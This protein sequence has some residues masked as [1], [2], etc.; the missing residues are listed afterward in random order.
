MTPESTLAPSIL[1]RHPVVI[2]GPQLLHELVSKTSSDTDIA[3]DFLEN[4]S[5]RRR[6]SYESLHVLSDGLA[7]TIT[8]VLEKLED[9][10]TIVPV[11]LP[12]SPELYVTLLAISKAGGSFCSLSPDTPT[13]RLNFILRDVS[14]KLII[15]DSAHASMIRAE[16]KARVLLVDQELPGCGNDPLSRRRAV[17]TNHLAYV[18]YTSGSTGLPK[19][20]C[21]SHR[22][23]TQSLLAHDRHI[24][25]FSRFL[26]FAAPTFDVSIFEI[27]FPWFRGCTLVG[28]T[29]AQM[30]NDLPATMASLEADAAEL[31]PT[32]CS[33]LMGR[34]SVPGLK[35][36]LTIG[37]MLTQSVV[38]EFGGDH[39]TD[40]ML[41]NMYGPTEASIHC[42]VQPSFT[43]SSPLSNIGFPLDTV[44]AMVVAPASDTLSSSQIQV[45]PVG[46]VGELVLGGPQI[47]EGYLNRPN[48]NKSFIRDTEYG[49]LY[50]TGDKARIGQ[51]GLLE[52][53]GRIAS[54]QVKLKGQR[55]ELGEIEQT[56]S[57]VDGCGAVV[58]M[59]I[60]DN[61]VAFCATGSRTLEKDAV[62][63]TCERWLPTFMIPTS[64]HFIRHM[65]LLESGK[66]NR[67]SLEAQYL[68][69]NVQEDISPLIPDDRTGQ[70]ILQTVKRHL[71]WVISLDSS[72]VSVGLD[73]LS[74]IQIASSLREQGYNLGAL[75]VLSAK[76]PKDLIRICQHTTAG[77][78]TISQQ[79]FGI[80]RE[81]ASDIPELTGLKDE[82][83]SI[84]PC[85]PLQEGML[86]ET[87]VR[88]NA[89]CNW[90]E[91]ELQSTRDF[92]EIRTLL[93]EI[94]Q[95]NEIL[96]SGFCMSTRTSGSFLQVV[97]KRLAQQ[98]IMEVTRFSKA[99]SLESVV[100]LLRPLVIQVNI[101]FERPRLLFQMH[102]ALYD[103]WSLDLLLNDLGTLRR[104]ATLD[105]RPQF[106]EVVKYHSLL[107]NTDELARDTEYWTKTLR[108]FHPISLPNFHGRILP[109]GT[110]QSV[111]LKSKINVAILHERA[112]ECGCNP[113]VFFQ[114]AVAYVM[115]L[116]LD[117]T[118]VVIGT[119][120][121]GR[122]IPITGIE[123]IQ[124]PCIASLPLRTDFSKCL[125]VSQLLK[126]VQ[127]TNRA[128]LQH[129]TLPLRDITKLCSSGGNLFEVLFVWQQNLISRDVED[130]GIK[131][132]D[133]ADVSGF[134]ITL[135]FEPHHDYIN[136]Q[137]TYDSTTIPEEQILFLSHQI[138][139]VVDYFL[140]NVD[141]TVDSVVNGFSTH[142]LSIAN[143]SPKWPPIRHGP[144][145]GVEQMAVSTPSKEAL[146]IG[147]I[148]DGIMVEKDK[149]T[150]GDL[151]ARANRVAHALISHG[152]GYDK[153]ICVLMEKSVNLYISILA[154][155]KVGSGYL[156]IAPDSP[157]ER[158]RKILADAGVEI[159]LSDSSAT[160]HL[161]ELGSYTVLDLDHIDLS[162][163]SDQNPAIAYDGAHL[164][165]AIFT[166]GSTGAPKGVLVTQDNLMSNLEELST[167]YPTSSDGRLLQSCSQA[168]DV[169]VFE[170]FFTW[171]NG[172]CL[173]TAAKDDLFYDLE[174]SI[175]QFGVTHLSLT[176][177]V[178]SLVDSS[179]VPKV[180]FLVTAGEAVT[181]HVKRQW[182][183]RGLYQGY[184]P[185]ETTNI[186][187]VRPRM[188][189]QDLINNIGS[190]LSN[191]SA[192]VL[193][194]NSV[195][196]RPR[197]A[198][199]ELCFGGAQVF[200]GYLNMPDL[201]A[202]KIV[203]HPRFGRIYRSGDMGM[204]LPDDSILF[205]RRVD[206]QVKIRGQRV[207]LA[208]ITST[209]LDNSTV[210]DCATLLL[211][212]DDSTQRLVAFWVPTEV[213]GQELKGAHALAVNTQVI[214]QKYQYSIRTIFDEL[215]LRLPS[216]MIPTHLVPI[217]RVPMTPQAK[218]DKRLLRTSFEGLTPEHLE[219][220]ASVQSS[221]E[222]LETLSDRERAFAEVLAQIFG[223]PPHRIRRSSSF[224]NMGLD[225]VSAIAF[226]SGLRRSGL[227]NISVSNILKNPTIARLS[228][229]D[230]AYPSASSGHGFVPLSS[231]FRQDQISHIRSEFQDRGLRVQQILPCTPIQEA[232]LSSTLRDGQMAYCNTMVFNV[233]GKMSRL[234]E[235]WSSIVARHAMLRTAFTQT[236]HEQYTFAQVVIENASIEWDQLRPTED[237]QLYSQRTLNGL[238]ESQKPPIGLATR[239]SG[240]LE[241][242]IFCCHHALYD[243][244]AISILEKEVQ[245]IYTEHTLPP[246]VP[247]EGYLQHMVSQDFEASD[248]FWTSALAGMEPKPFPNLTEKAQIATS[249]SES[250]GTVLQSP[251]GDVL[252][253]C[254]S[255]SVSLL[256]V[257][258][259]TWVKLLYLYTGED[260][261]CF[262]NV[263]SGRT[264]P[265]KD[266]DRLVAP[267]FNTLP[268]RVN[269]DF[270]RS[271]A[272]LIKQLHS[273]NI[274]SSPFQLTPLRRIQATAR[275]DLGH[276]FDTAVILQQPHE[277]LDESIWSLAHD[278]GSMDIPV[279]CEV[280][281]D[282]EDNLLRLVLHH[283]TS[284]FSTKEA[285]IIAETFDYVLQALL[286]FPASPAK[287]PVGFPPKILAESNKDFISH[288]LGESELLHS[289]ME[290]NAML[291]PDSIALEFHDGN[292]KTTWSFGILNERANEIAY[293]LIK[294][295]VGPED[296][297]PV[298]ISKSPQF[299]ASMLGILKAGAAFAPFAPFLPTTR[300]RFMLSD[301]RPKVLICTK[302]SYPDWCDNVDILNVD[303][304]EE[305]S[306]TNP[307]IRQ[308]SGTNLAYCLYTSGST[309]TPK[310]VLME[311]R[312]PIQ[313]IESSR[314]LIPWERRTSRLLQYAAITFDMCYYDC[315]LAWTFGFTLCAAEQ[316]SML[317]HLASTINSLDV[318]ILDLTPSVASIISR[319]EV[320]S[321]KW[322]FCIGETMLPEIV[323]EWE[324]TCVNSFGP[325]ETAF[326]NTIFAVGKNIKTTIIGKP[327][328]TTSFSVF[329]PKSTQSLPI[330]AVGELGIGG[331]Q[332]ARGYHG[333]AELTAQKF[334]YANGQRFY[335]SGDMV[336]MLANGNFEF[337]GRAD[338]QVKIR[339]LRVELGEISHALRNS[340]ENITTVTTQVLTLDSGTK[341]Q[342]VAFIVPRHPV[343][344]QEKLE[345]TRHAERA[346]KSSLP[347]YMVPQFFIFI[348]AIPLSFA[349]KVD[350]SALKVFFNNS[351]EARFVSDPSDEA[352]PEK[353]QWSATESQ[354]REVFAK[355]SKTTLERIYP[356][357]S[358][359]QLGLDSISAVQ[360]AAALQKQGL[361]VTAT[362]VMKYMNCTDLAAHID[363]SDER[364][365]PVEIAFDF[366]DFHK[367]HVAEITDELGVNKEDIEAIRPCTQLQKS[368]ISQFIAKDGAVYLNYV[369]F[370]LGADV[371]LSRLKAAWSSTMQKHVML[372]T[373][374]AHVQDNRHAFVMI[375]LTTAA[376][377]LP[378]NDTTETSNPEYDGW[379]DRMKN[380]VLNQLHRPPW[381][382]RIV[383]VGDTTC[384]DLAIHHALFDAQSLRRILQDVSHTYMGVVPDTPPPLDPALNKVLQLSERK[385]TQGS[386]FWQRLGNAATPT[387][388]PNVAPLRY[389]LTEPVTAT[390][391]CSHSLLDLEAGCRRLNITLQAAGIAAWASILSQYTGEPTITTGVVLS[392]RNFEGGELVVFPC[393]TT[394]PFVCNVSDNKEAMLKDIMD[395]SAEMQQHQFTPLNTIQG[396]MG[397]PN[398][399]LFDSIFAYQKFSHD[400]RQAE[401]WT[402]VDEKATVEFPISIELE[403]KNDRLE[404]RLSFL[405]HAVPTEQATLILDQLDHM[406]S[407]YV[408]LDFQA[409][410]MFYDPAIYSITPAKQ[411]SLPSKANLLHELVELTAL[412][413]P[414]RIALEFASTVRKEEY[415]SCTWTYAQLDAEGN[416]I[417]H[418]IL[419]HGVRPESLVGICFDKCPEASFAILGILKA[420]SAFVA[421]DPGSPAARQAFI[422][423]DSRVQIVLSMKNQSQRLRGKL[424]VRILDLDQLDLRSFPRTK[425]SLVRAIGPQDRSYC[426]YT[427][428]TT[429]TPKGCELTHE[430][431]VQ[432][433]LSFERLF[434]GHWN[435]ESRWLQFA[436][437]HFDVSVLEQYWS[438]MVGICVVSA[439]RDLLF[440]DLAGS[441]ES[442]RITHI[443]LTPS[444]ARI[445]HPD[446]VPSLCKGVFITGGESLTQEIL[447]VWG[448]KG[449]IYNG[450]GPTET[451]IGI[452]MYPGVPHN[453]KPSNIGRQFDNV[454]SFVLNPASEVPVLRGAIGEL[455]VSGKLVGKGYLNRPELTKERFPTLAHFNERV[456][457][458]GDLV[459]ILHDNDFDFI[460][461]VD[462][463]VKLRGQRLEIGEINSVIKRSSGGIL[464]VATLVLK[465]PKQQKD[466]LVSFVVSS[467]TSAEPKIVLESTTDLQKA[468]QACDE[469]LPGYMIPTHLLSITTLPLS[470]NNKI[471]TRKLR[472]MYEDLSGND[473]QLLSGDP[474]KEVIWSKDERK[475]RDVLKQVLEIDHDTIA[476]ESSFFELG[477]D[478]ISVIGLS[479][480]F[481]QAGFPNAT[482]SVLMKHTTIGKIAKVLLMDKT[483]DRG[484]IIAAQQ[485]ITAIQHRHRRGVADT[486]LVD[487][488][489]IEALA[490]CTPLQQGMIARALDSDRGLYFNAFQFKLDHSIN[491]DRLH[492][493]W[494]EVFR[495]TPILRT[496]FANTDDGYVQ[497]V[498][499]SM[500][501]P[502]RVYPLSEEE[503]LKEASE[504]LQREWW[505]LNRKELRRPFE[506]IFAT[507][508]EKTVLIVHIFHALYDGNSIEMM[509]RA[510]WNHYNGS[511]ESVERPSFLSALPHGP[512][513]IVD[514]SEEFWKTHL[515]NLSFTP[516]P[517][518]VDK[519][520]EG[521]IMVTRHARGVTDF[522][523]TRR[524]LNVTAQAIV[525]ACWISVM[526][527]HIHGPVTL[528]MVVSGR[529]IDFEGADRVIGP[530]FNTIPYQYRPRRSATWSSLIKETHD[531]NVAAHPFQHTP[532]RDIMKWCK[533]S[534][535]QP[536]FDTLFVYR[537]ANND[538]A[539]ANNGLAVLEDGEVEADFPL[540]IEIE[541]R[542][543]SHL[544]FTLVSQGHVL[545]R[546]TSEQLLNSLEESLKA[547]LA[548]PE[549]AVE[550]YYREEKFRNQESKEIAPRPIHSD[551]SKFGWTPTASIIRAEISSLAGIQIEGI[552]PSTSIFEL[553]LDSIDAIKLSSKLKKHDID[554]PV[555]GIMRSLTIAKMEINTINRQEWSDQP[556]NMIFET[557][558]RRLEN[559][560]RRR[561][562]EKTEIEQ[563]LPLTPLQEAMVA[564]MSASGYTRYYNHDVLR[565]APNT[566]I[567]KLRKAW[568]EVVEHSPILRTSFIEIDDPNIDYS[569]AQ[570]INRT[571]HY[572][573]KHKEITGQPD[574]A[575]IFESIRQDVAK[576][577]Y[578]GPPF[579]I[580]FLDSSVQ[581][582]L[583]LSIAHALYDGWSLSLL[584]ADVQDAYLGR[585]EAR[586]SYE[587]TLGEILT[588]S[589]TDAV[590]FWRDY[591]SDAKPTVFPR[592]QNPDTKKPVKVYRK[593]QTSA[594]D[595][596]SITSFAKANGTSLQTLG[597]T[598]YALVLASYLKSF[599]VTFGS[600]LSGRDDAV[601]SE[602]L[603]PTMTTVAV[604]TI[605]HGSCRDML[606]YVQESFSSI[607][608]YQNLPL[609][610][611]QSVAGIQGNLFESLFIYQKRNNSGGSSG[612]ELYTSV[613][614]QSDVEYPLCVEMELIDE[615]LVWRCALK[616]DMFEEPEAEKL[617]NTLD[618][619]L[620]RLI[621]HTDSPVI[622][623]EAN[624]A[625]IC[626]LPAL[627]HE[628]T[629]TPDDI[630]PKMTEA[631]APGYSSTKKTIREV[632]AF[633]SKTPEDEITDD[634]T[635]FHVGLDSISAIKVS[636]L[637]RKRSVDISVGEMMKA[638]TIKKMAQVADE[639]MQVEEDDEK[640]SEDILTQAMRGVLYTDALRYMGLTEADIE[641]VLPTTAGQIYM[642][643]MWLRSSGVLFYP[644]F[645]YQLKGAVSFEVLQ[646]SWKKLVIRN[647][648][649]RTC[650]LSTD[651]GSSSYVQVVRREVNCDITEW[652]QSKTSS[653]VN[654][655][656]RTQ[657]CVYLFAAKN[658]TGWDLKLRIH[659]ALYDGVSLPLLMQQL[660]DLCNGLTLPAPPPTFNKL[661]ASST[662]P[663][664]IK[665]RKA[666]WKHYLNNVT[667]H[668][669]AQPSSPI[670]SKTEIFKP[671]LLPS[672]N[673][674][675]SLARR[676]G[677][678][679]HSLLL[680]VVAKLYAAL[681]STPPTSD[682]VI[683]IYLANRSLP[684]AH[685]ASAAVP[686]LNVL[687]LR[688]QAPLDENNTLFNIAAQILYDL[689]KICSVANAGARLKEIAEWT[690]VRVDLWVNFL[691]LPDMR[692]E[693][694]ELQGG[695]GE[696]RVKIAHEGAWEG[697]VSRVREVVGGDGFEAPRELG[698]MDDVHEAYLVSDIYPSGKSLSTTWLAWRYAN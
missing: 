472:R 450:Y 581:S 264:L 670:T 603:F 357:T 588:T 449:V 11:L 228:A 12:Q 36:L 461:R 333:N 399:P 96:R 129:C 683:G 106:R 454:G 201:N 42:A 112:R 628:E 119:V 467:S 15:T 568:E 534:P 610:K 523:S 420:G 426:L 286:Q 51:S 74:S 654:D 473:L 218:L 475:I 213:S 507:S 212:L 661:L 73:S 389:N 695:N 633:V 208:E 538:D 608:P 329:A 249:R 72:L 256:P 78:I 53:L 442:L 251:L 95:T 411:Q 476:K 174:A 115:S 153:L 537:I 605:L 380:D 81:I 423:E 434:A 321:V 402:I 86:A 570:I 616:G 130:S 470:A 366:E 299:Y 551:D 620:K 63:A 632:L 629:T 97:W 221:N 468:K 395:L 236:D 250:F 596:V 289:G 123:K 330:L 379:L 386:E 494:E 102:H 90:V 347:S 262:G 509:F 604:R 279:V 314:T 617:L 621:Q 48:E 170:I 466:Q 492:D 465:H 125:H 478:S 372:R 206:D 258:Q 240:S 113:Q 391:I 548:D 56:I 66:I 231:V 619:I 296:I 396:L 659:H 355:I 416:Q 70:A 186:A 142:S 79:D 618:Q 652:E 184:G 650:F 503:S 13:E 227:G 421:L 589:G 225:S 75:D 575:E 136:L 253:V 515:A 319:A 215:K 138:D 109:S 555:S 272:E 161:R 194:P 362:D 237:V 447:D 182:A 664:A 443:D 417:A 653:T 117:S 592:L 463:Q 17:T 27:F 414:N 456:Y 243:G 92:T 82:I 114:S 343:S 158:T 323:E 445:L 165:Y 666:F 376:F 451:T 149:L 536:L 177:T 545:D 607:K 444:L 275:N 192:F 688:V 560:A 491:Q 293:A 516:F 424:D 350:K 648:I 657:P 176:P 405:P 65:P 490:P 418:L 377:S 553:G 98:Q 4:G 520:S 542:G 682:V 24:P 471:D 160:C 325:T 499:R 94:A 254:Q 625:S 320:P 163:Y 26:Q 392:G 85:A 630:S 638:G 131:L 483:S 655:R 187:T 574:F 116:Y 635:I 489:E 401:L 662:T 19:A 135:E 217:N 315:F 331:V 180:K 506:V 172:M 359:F 150:Y 527:R 375:H 23:A 381:R 157:P 89:Y 356:T 521:A 247:F 76:T 677:I 647:P 210:R 336:R 694:G 518:L 500:P 274:D 552:R 441:I 580:H 388:F 669:L 412:K 696:H 665:A 675:A 204:L 45:L 690:G 532:L 5:K 612:P 674:L 438:W 285:K 305:E 382:V 310:A 393:I 462:D 280:L 318:S 400:E 200:R 582:Y 93:E 645:A 474:Q 464:D 390:R 436:S 349:G 303:T 271:N 544:K 147:H 292:A 233:S 16:R 340:H 124:G 327:F 636:S 328:A 496:V 191:T 540:A 148:R 352:R 181:E 437:F 278:L 660:Q 584:H 593:E 679:T 87:I 195:T 345:L 678:T 335:K 277:R 363:R 58:V 425:P 594:L 33:L 230:S 291:Q 57:K 107:R 576:A 684:I 578:T 324:G 384:L 419:S 203:N 493:S 199:G 140:H 432:A 337:L 151:N 309:G 602:L 514:G 460:G 127:D 143:P 590:V 60:K 244:I 367:N 606:Q 137:A 569:F 344:G 141:S 21:V 413:Y 567:E 531:F 307:K 485:Y 535:D 498:R 266:L 298:H 488:R 190:P 556:S 533:R 22:A 373:G 267:C 495:S 239:K 505:Q 383:S 168:F 429:G 302:E 508:T 269:F 83:E 601:K 49:Y 361:H 452:T 99:Y 685:I 348:D 133:S 232:M 615:E 371:Q 672:V 458:T 276:L 188:S 146:I 595:L 369:R 487:T 287:D 431:A 613:Q 91:I 579:H 207:E 159:C 18:L 693:G 591:L 121:S 385:S 132:I 522:E 457:R 164:A 101:G 120:T 29:R 641:Q 252:Q 261:L 30:L 598:T 166:S 368:M 353:H 439:P 686:T 440:E 554:L 265:V 408:F 651:T 513:R 294:Q 403:P 193:D 634:M 692:D 297:V 145:Y 80:P 126:D 614:G 128:M 435:E 640:S 428:G 455:C 524:N 541:Q 623:F 175:R 656:T 304:L 571:P 2:E 162:M 374:F 216:Y 479:R 398:E 173:C 144:S 646:E 511:P 189:S 697:G 122:T 270:R 407:R 273:F 480:A 484:S 611:V 409:T 354:I 222:S 312:S 433:M 226:S 88:P 38:D 406:M 28:C 643:S 205:T 25:K 67:K 169:S 281:Q 44:S 34:K 564:E 427:S 77:D 415:A 370:Q 61:L 668:H 549:A 477:M 586:P 31:T 152:V 154:V 558:K 37:E 360:I 561:G 202:E 41:W 246:P 118:D 504:K 284:H 526:H 486:L 64:V 313:T 260:D 178:A 8:S 642:L 7:S 469:T 573:W 55:V 430:N 364:I 365:A 46:E 282:K 394:V 397:Y 259:A 563:I 103:G 663:P 139:D 316:D 35:L 110:L 459:R 378:W 577:T 387:H 334:V 235:C 481:K 68:Q 671:A 155:L 234:K 547:A 43:W 9:D 179:C 104:G 482:A 52:C 223:L 84:L 358:I 583:V 687:P 453:G 565:I 351:E 680:A 585:F 627:E 341:D 283:H 185:A 257:I 609:R 229:T 50:R 171:N 134:K 339:G 649:L 197:G 241:Q 209:I 519:P 517:N 626:G 528:G 14:A 211:Q 599:D 40:S 587:A 288:S 245:Q 529:S 422:V 183:D 644:E 248:R 698:G 667:Q 676:H 501:F 301:L 446:D 242:L 3:I 332:V 689:Q 59:V 404:F 559:Y 62:V 306:K 322:L 600:V 39:S 346:A 268:V 546:R 219:L 410:D 100:S 196:V 308:L 214:T 198:I 167:I 108:D 502:W 497:A 6:I 510:V 255:L 658:T 539:W 681:T 691:N 622:S 54:G 156:P 111:Q 637:L 530:L 71:N 300:K 10:A 338:D 47:A 597:Q 20:V 525:Q 448:P 562:A 550:T 224:F 105:A 572:F 32:A 263:V 342:L 69:K 512:L 326:C 631:A 566:D 543:N 317:T 290:R 220:V 673:T 1:N 238:L 624:G 311:H 295:G 557:H 639:R